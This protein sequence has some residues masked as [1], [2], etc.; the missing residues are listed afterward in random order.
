MI[1]KIG[2]VLAALFA[3][4]LLA[5]SGLG[6]ASATPV[7]KTVTG[8]TVCTTSSTG[9]CTINHDLGTTPLSVVVT[10]QGGAGF[11]NAYAFTTTDFKVHAYAPNGTS[12]NSKVITVSWAAFAGT[13]TE[14]TTQPTTP[15][16]SPTTTVPTTVPTSTAPPT[17]QPTTDPPAAWPNESNTGP[18]ADVVLTNYTGPLTITAANTV[19]DSKTVNGDLDIRATGVMIK[20]SVINGEVSNYDNDATSSFTI[21]DS[22]VHNGKRDACMC[23]GSHN[24]IALRIEVIGGN[25]GM[26][27]E[28]TCTITDSYIHGT[29]LKATQ[30]ASAIRVE[31]N[32]T[33]RHNTL[34]C[35]WTAITDSEIGCSADMTGYPDFA[36]IKNNTIDNNFFAANPAGLGFCAYGGGTNGKP[37]SGDPTNATNIKFTDNVFE[38]G[39]NNKCGTWGPITDFISGRAGNVW[40]GNVWDN[41][42]VVPPG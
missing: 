32:T 16:T 15:S 13:T 20:N 38:R 36:P 22:I 11:A 5:F 42:G 29:D 4:S 27:C 3:V 2:L 30:H 41:G 9:L 18:A 28:S 26:Y 17:T 39:S 19:I 25:R 21:Q 14:P 37:F 8:N 10:V 24:F 35:D 33:L 23:V 34:K 31:Q 40:T 1:K 12:A 7:A 6:V